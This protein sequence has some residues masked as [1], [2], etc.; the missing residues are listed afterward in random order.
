MRSNH[1]PSKRKNEYFSDKPQNLGQPSDVDIPAQGVQQQEMCTDIPSQGVQQQPMYA[2]FPAQGVQQVYT[3]IIAQGVQQQPMCVN[4][5]AQGVQ[6][7]KAYT[8][9]PDQGAQQQAGYA[10]TPAQELQQQALLFDMSLVEVDNSMDMFISQDIKTSNPM[11]NPNNMVN[12]PMNVGPSYDMQFN[13]SEE[14]SSAQLLR[15]MGFNT[16]FDAGPATI[17][18]LDGN[19]SNTI[20]QQVNQPSTPVPVK[21]EAKGKLE[22]TR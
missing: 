4:I 14:F 2:N 20:Y 12:T 9:V 15:S 17:L 19:Y 22:P 13:N 8:N 16:S 11:V 21:E 1:L 18:P 3:D 10:N 7:Q 6:Q 5:P